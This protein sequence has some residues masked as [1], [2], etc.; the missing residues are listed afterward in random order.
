MIGFAALILAQAASPTGLVYLHC[1]YNYQGK[2]DAQD[3]TL[4]E[5]AGKVDYTYPTG[6]ERVI[7]RFTADRVYFLH[8][9]ISRLDLTIEDT[10]YA[11]GTDEKIGTANGKC[12]LINHANRAF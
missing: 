10:L 7:A 1:I 2:V 6:S 11:F 4:N 12:A 9:A 8:Y 3:I 5:S